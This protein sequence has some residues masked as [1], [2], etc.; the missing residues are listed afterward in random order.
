[1]NYFSLCVVQICWKFSIV[2][3]SLQYAPMVMI[4]YFR[5]WITYDVALNFLKWAWI[6]LFDLWKAWSTMPKSTHCNVCQLCFAS[7]AYIL[8]EH[9][10]QV[11]DQRNISPLVAA[12]K[13][14]HQKV[15]SA[16]LYNHNTC[17]FDKRKIWNTYQFAY[18]QHWTMQVNRDD[19]GVGGGG[20]GWSQ[21]NSTF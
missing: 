1:M 4:S 19:S 7:A 3:P 10:L 14:G 17:I 11:C 12:F 21:L 9:T 13:N 18:M 6:T 16:S 5:L 15:S 8:I 2:A 20:G